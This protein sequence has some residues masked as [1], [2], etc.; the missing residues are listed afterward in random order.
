MPAIDTLKIDK[1]LED[2]IYQVIDNYMDFM[3]KK[4][5]PVAVYSLHREL[6][7]N[8]KE[9]VPLNLIDFFYILKKKRLKDIFHTSDS[10][11]P[12][13]ND[14][15]DT[16]LFTDGCLSELATDFYMDYKQSK[17]D[18]LQRQQYQMKDFLDHCRSQI[19]REKYQNVYTAV[20]VKLYNK[21]FF[22]NGNFQ[23]E[24]ALNILLENELELHFIELA[25]LYGISLSDEEIIRGLYRKIN[26]PLKFEICNYC[27]MPMKSKNVCY[28]NHVC[29][30]DHTKNRQE[31]ETFLLKQGEVAY[32]PLDG[33][34][35]FNVLPG[36][37]EF[38]IY[39]ILKKLFE[40]E[41][42]SVN[43]FP[44]L[45]R[46]GD[47]EILAGKKRILIDVKDYRE[48]ERLARHIN[49]RIGNYFNLEYVHIPKYRMKGSD[50]LRVLR[51]Q[52]NKDT[53]FKVTGKTLKFVNQKQ[54][55]AE[56]EDVLGR[57]K[58][59]A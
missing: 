30:H 36:I 22:Q 11:N 45:E 20:R 37:E 2:L 14:L 34:A 6:V 4:E 18:P 53:F 33:I 27:K 50:Y 40:N 54:L 48:P 19:D 5:V 38:R 52:V 26:G 13:F 44:N 3:D 39:T 15:F 16:T 7:L 29:F 59:E 51:D 58:N 10:Q 1:S 56:I 23:Y 24:P 31:R 17:I 21:G 32:I 28:N 41:S 46:D 57:L 9:T 49:E 25:D 47:I 55:I 8:Y 35:Y 43:L 42:I 12:L